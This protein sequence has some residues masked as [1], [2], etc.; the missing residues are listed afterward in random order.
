MNTQIWYTIINPKSG[1][2]KG[3]KDWSEIRHLL[4]DQQ[5]LFDFHFTEKPHHAIN[6]T[7]EA[8]DQGFKQ[9]LIIGGDGTMNEVLNAMMTHSEVKTSEITIGVIPVGTGNDWCRSQDI[10]HDYK[11]AIEI[12]CRGHKK[13]LDVG[14]AV[15]SNTGTIRYFSN[16]AGIGFDAEVVEAVQKKRFENGSVSTL[17]YLWYMLKELMST[18]IK[19]LHLQWKEGLYEGPL[20]TGAVAIG[21]Y[22]GGGMKQAPDA[23]SDDGLLDITVVGNMSKLKIL[24]NLPRLYS[25]SFVKMKEVSQYR[26][27]QLSM[28]SPETVPVETDG[29]TAGC[30]PVDFS[31]IPST[32]N[33]IV[34][35]RS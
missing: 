32:L 18:K 14:K 16:I 26:T 25:G 22:N 4:E 34:P 33:V 13:L 7:H 35:I 10:P 27:E 19:P 20:L 3:E 24:I 6:L 1:N 17:G 9:I 23:I 15:F 8:L 29:E 28:T 11:K 12:F 5:I 31:V 21:Q 30:T 2:G